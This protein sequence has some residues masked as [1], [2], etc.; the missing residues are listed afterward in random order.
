LGEGAGY[1]SHTLSDN[2]RRAYDSDWRTFST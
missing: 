1:A 2:T